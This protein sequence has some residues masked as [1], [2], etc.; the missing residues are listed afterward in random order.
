LPGTDLFPYKSQQRK[1]G[2][3]GFVL[4]AW[5]VD[6]RPAAQLRQQLQ[7]LEGSPPVYGSRVNVLEFTWLQVAMNVRNRLPHEQ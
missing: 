3:Y 5:E 4:D 1:A 6:A 7:R 2:S